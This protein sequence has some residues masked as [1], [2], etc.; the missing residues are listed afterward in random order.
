MTERIT[1]T[2]LL[3]QLD[4]S[5]TGEMLRLQDIVDNF[6]SRGFG[7]LLVLPALIVLLPTGAIPTIPTLC[8]LFIAT[9]AGQLAL[10][11]TSPWLPRRL[12]RRGISHDR[13]HRA[14]TRLKPWTERFDK[15]LK[16]RLQAF[17]NPLSRRL[18]AALAVM[19]ALSMIPLEL[20]PFAAALPALAIALMGLGLAAEDGLV[21][22]IGLAVVIGGGVFLLW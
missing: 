8:G 21:M 3:E 15:L 11:K 4:E 19:L 1:L 13:F 16:P 10:G 22:L 5:G 2:R 9:L 12:G 7:P 18:I 17:A 20:L 6:D 14:V